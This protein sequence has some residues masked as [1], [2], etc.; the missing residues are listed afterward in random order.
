MFTKSTGLIPFDFVIII[1]ILLS[2]DENNN[3]FLI[4]SMLNGSQE[5]NKHILEYEKYS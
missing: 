3:K 4:I 5:L 1:D 2:K